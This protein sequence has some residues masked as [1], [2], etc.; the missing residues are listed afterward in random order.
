LDSGLKKYKGG[1]NMTPNIETTI[2]NDAPE[3]FSVIMELTKQEKKEL[4]K[5]WKESGLCKKKKMIYFP[6]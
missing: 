2:Y 3:D 1:R 5:M 4:L 6:R